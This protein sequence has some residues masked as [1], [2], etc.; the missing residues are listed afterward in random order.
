MR[1]GLEPGICLWAWLLSGLRRAAAG[2]KYLRLLAQVAMSCPC[3]LSL[4]W[5]LCDTAGGGCWY[6]CCRG[7][8]CWGEG[9]WGSAWWREVGWGESSWDGWFFK[10]AAKS[11]WLPRLFPR[12]W[13][14]LLRYR[15]LLLEEDSLGLP[16]KGDAVGAASTLG[17]PSDLNRSGL[18]GK[19]RFGFKHMKT[20]S[21]LRKCI[22][23]LVIARGGV[24][25]LRG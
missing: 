5:W 12:R 9:Y 4:G 13:R 23:G 16:D 24:T 7:L 15:L 14:G 2:P 21:S 19:N 3:I 6:C 8:W 17:M 1:S 22:P 11:L 18:Q 25:G 20:H 10:M